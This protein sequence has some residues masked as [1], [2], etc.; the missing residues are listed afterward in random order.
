MNRRRIPALWDRGVDFQE[1]GD[2]PLFDLYG[3][4]WNHLGSVSVSFSLLMCYNEPIL[5]LKV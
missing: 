1:L 5:R 2:Y 3:E 4:P